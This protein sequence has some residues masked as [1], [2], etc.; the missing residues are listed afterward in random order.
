[1]W[2]WC[3]SRWEVRLE[4]LDVSAVLRALFGDT[5]VLFQPDEAAR[6]LKADVDKHQ[7]NCQVEIETISDRGRTR[8]LSMMLMAP[9]GVLAGT[10][11]D[12]RLLLVHDAQLPAA[13]PYFVQ[14]VFG[15]MAVVMGA[16][17]LSSR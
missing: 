12:L 13:D 4:K 17:A 10:W 16:R 2:L 8:R 11:P 3:S 7:A 1:M 14:A 9:M 15:V 5:T 6:R